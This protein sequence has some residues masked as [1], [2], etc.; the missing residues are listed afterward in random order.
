MSG[1][2]RPC[3]LTVAGDQVENAGGQMLAAELTDAQQPERR[4]FC[5]F[6]HKRVAGGNRHRNLER[7]END[8]RIPRHDAAYDADRFSARVTE[9]VLAERY[10]FAFRFARDPAVIAKHVDRRYDFWTRL[11]AERVP[12]FERNDASDRLHFLLD[13]V[14]NPQQQSAA[15]ARRYQAPR[16]ERARGSIHSS[17][18]IGLAAAR[19]L[20]DRRPGGGVFNVDRTTV[21]RFHV[22]AIDQ[23]QRTRERRLVSGKRWRCGG[24]VVSRSANLSASLTCGTRSMRWN[25]QRSQ[26][27]AS[28]STA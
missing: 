3:L 9:N 27:P 6:Q 26:R 19:Y 13:S 28:P 2:C 7:S 25:R 23:H 18:H 4:V 21:R 8:R 24:H 22:P 5:G 14:G 16:L 20:R 1:Q 10:R 12:G 17:R 11:R 15:F